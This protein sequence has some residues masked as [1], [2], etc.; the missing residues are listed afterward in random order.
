MRFRTVS[1]NDAYVVTRFVVDF[2]CD[3]GVVIIV[4]RKCMDIMCINVE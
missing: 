1:F 2:V 4:V 3:E